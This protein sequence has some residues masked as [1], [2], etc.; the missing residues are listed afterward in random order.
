MNIQ[1]YFS[2]VGDID[3]DKVFRKIENLNSGK[4]D[5]ANVEEYKQ[6][7]LQNIKRFLY[8]V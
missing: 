8:Y 4:I 7:T 2:S 5:M 6:R 3:A 1:P